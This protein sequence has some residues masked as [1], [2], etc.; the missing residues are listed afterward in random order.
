MAKMTVMT[1][2]SFI[3]RNVIKIILYSSTRRKWRT[4]YFCG[5]TFSR[6]HSLKP[7]TASVEITVL[8]ENITCGYTNAINILK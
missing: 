3:V 4:S 5:S 8:V 1:T 6:F 7:F 2:V